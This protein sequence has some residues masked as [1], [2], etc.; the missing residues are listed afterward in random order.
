MKLPTRVTNRHDFGVSSRVVRRRDLIAAFTYDLAILN[1]DASERTAK[2]VIHATLS[3]LDR[4]PHKS[5]VRIAHLLL[6]FELDLVEVLPPLPSDE[7]AVA[8]LVVSDAIQRVLTFLIFILIFRRD[9]A[10]VDPPNDLSGR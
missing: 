6:R 7:D 4:P 5:F 3:E 2:T 9:P 1:D 10:E 8:G